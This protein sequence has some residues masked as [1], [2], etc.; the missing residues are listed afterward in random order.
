[1]PQRW[2]RRLASCIAIEL[3]CTAALVAADAEYKAGAAVAAGVR[4]LALED[5]HGNR[6]VIADAD[7]VVVR[8]MSDVVSATVL[9][10]YELDRGFVLLRGSGPRRVTALAF[11]E[12][13]RSAFD[14]L[15]PATLRSDGQMLHAGEACITAAGALEV[16]CAMNAGSAPIVRAPLRA[17]QR[18]S[19]A[20]ASAPC[21]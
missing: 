17:A 8:Q 4:A 13:I 18:C 7:G 20:V 12:A 3:L 5:R 15:A 16:P 1:M 6:A 9:K 19:S 14:R 10:Q 2:L 11:L 21:R